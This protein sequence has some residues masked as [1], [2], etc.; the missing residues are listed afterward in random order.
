MYGSEDPLLPIRFEWRY[1]GQ[2]VHLCGSFTRWLET[3]PMAPSSLEPQ[4][5]SH[6]PGRPRGLGQ[7]TPAVCTSERLGLAGGRPCEPATYSYG[8]HFGWA[9]GCACGE[10]MTTQRPSPG[11][12]TKMALRAGQWGDDASGSGQMM[13]ARLPYTFP[14]RCTRAAAP[15]GRYRDAHSPTPGNG[16]GRHRT[17]RDDVWCGQTVAPTACARVLQHRDRQCSSSPVCGGLWPKR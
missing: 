4:V 12:D 16:V 5:P 8:V 13:R 2:Q 1:G 17:R 7:N 6:G 14:R 3:V 10:P 15:H 11:S 9:R